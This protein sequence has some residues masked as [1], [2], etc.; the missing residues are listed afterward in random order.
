MQRG[1]GSSVGGVTGSQ[2]TGLFTAAGRSRAATGGIG[3]G[4]GGGG[5]GGGG[6][7]RGG[8]GPMRD[9]GRKRG[10]K[11]SS[12]LRGSGA[13]LPAPGG[14]RSDR[15]G[16]M[17]MGDKKT[18]FSP[19]QRPGRNRNDAVVTTDSNSNDALVVFV[20]GK[21]VGSDAGLLDFLSRKAS[22]AKITPSNKKPNADRSSISFHVPNFQQA[23]ALKALSGIR[24]KGQKI[25]IKTTADQRILEESA[26]KGSSS[27]EQST[28]TIDAIRSFIRSRYNNGFLDLENMAVD[29]TLRAAAILPP[30]SA[31]GKFDVGAVFM[32]VAA[33]LFPETTTI[34]FASNKLRS[35]RA[36]ASVTRFFPNIQNLSFKNN[37]ISNFRDL[38]MMGGAKK[39]TM[40]RELIL[41]D[42]PIRDQDIAKNKDDIEYRSRVTKMFPTIQVLDQIPV[43]PKITFGLGDVASSATPATQ[44]LPAPVRGNFFDSPGTE[45][46]V[47]EFLTS[48]FQLFDSDRSALE[49]MYDNSA[50][51]SYS[52]VRAPATVQKGKGRP[53]DDSWVDYPQGRNLSRIKDLKQRTNTIHVGNDAIVKQGLL[54]LPKTTHNLSDASKVRVDAWQ[55]GTL[56]P[57]I[58]IYIMVHGEFTQSN[59]KQ[60]S[61]DRSFIIAPAPP[62][63][64]AAARGWKCLII[65]DQLTIRTYGGS[66]AWQPE[67]DPSTP[68]ATP[69]PN[70]PTPNMQPPA[71]PNVGAGPDPS[72][73]PMPGINAEQ[74]AKA[75]ELQQLTGLNYPY[76]VQCL[77]AVAWDVTAGVALVNQERANIPQDAWQKPRF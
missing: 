28:G 57:A 23:S 32:K 62:T 39:L 74:H 29:P 77:T 24:Y 22:P 61:F 8:G 18:N 33:E 38:E 31:K 63:S 9:N 27:M 40:L 10:G 50:T 47:L 66:D 76:S 64:Q 20:I 5:G 54:P 71:T 45:S 65:T 2:E 51:F 21:G 6:G 7:G 73:T 36:I 46:L 11:R 12:G 58:C 48:F 42:N 68:A 67:P 53:N 72:Q 4:H 26:Q 3:G 16:D 41:L 55:T 75:Q 70:M 59:G 44:R 37:L 52:T 25:I 1:G 56:L 34:S 17:D 30:G 49:H 13:H 35:L 15:D 19:Y 69:T 60:K 43:G 14:G